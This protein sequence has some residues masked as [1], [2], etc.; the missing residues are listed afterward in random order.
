M[1]ISQVV[2]GAGPGDAVTGAA[3]S[4]QALLAA[5]GQPSEV[6]GW[7]IDPRLADRVRPLTSFPRDETDPGDDLVV[8][9]VSIGQPEV[10]SWLRQGRERLVVC[11][12]N[13]S[14]SA[15]F[16]D[17]DPAFARLLDLGRQDLIEIQERTEL[18]LADS[19]YNAA[20]LV[21][22]GYR[23]VRVSPLVYDPRRLTGI[24]PHPPTANHLQE[25]IDGPIV[26]AV[27][28]LLPHKRPDWLIEA[29]FT[30]STYLVPEA[31]LI[32]AG[33]HRLPRYTAAVQVFLKEL[34]LGRVWL[35]GHVSDEELAAFYRHADVFVTAS[36]HEGFCAPL[37]EAMAFDVPVVARDFAAVGETL[38][39]GGLLLAAG[40]PP[41]VMAEALAAVIETPATSQ[42]LV[43]RGRRRLADFPPGQAERTFVEHLR[44][45][46]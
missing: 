24:T 6:Y 10:S 14:P 20:E 42:E 19:A 8:L 21:A 31:N 13:I 4:I 22:L 30:L 18:A 36:E 44:S 28:Q 41:E 5:E 37:L 23:D 9:H 29:F 38:G 26:L 25:A 12:H 3:L 32:L 40:D 43:R 34:N 35:T 27:G 2:V 7:H 11:Y 17:H 33:A 15:A 45:I 1:R 39:D 16:A 46:R